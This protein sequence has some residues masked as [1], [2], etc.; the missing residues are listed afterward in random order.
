MKRKYDTHT[1]TAAR[2]GMTSG[3]LVGSVTTKPIEIGSVSVKDYEAGFD[4][5][6]SHDNFK[7]ISFA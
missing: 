5:G 7:Q 4:E 2:I 6:A 1:V 3:L